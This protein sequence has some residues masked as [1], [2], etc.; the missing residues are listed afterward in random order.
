VKVILFVEEGDDIEKRNFQIMAMSQLSLE[1]LSSV[2]LE[3]RE[4]G[5]HLAPVG[6]SSVPWIILDLW[7]GEELEGNLE[8]GKGV[9]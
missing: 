7:E 1:A 4:L 6:P 8:E 5:S 3:L 9:A 2:G